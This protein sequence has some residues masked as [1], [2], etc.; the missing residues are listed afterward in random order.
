MGEAIRSDWPIYESIMGEFCVQ[1][2]LV[3]VFSRP[4]MLDL[5][6]LM[7]ERLLGIFPLPAPV[8][9][10]DGE[11]RTPE[12][13]VGEG[14]DEEDP[15]LAGPVPAQPARQVGDH[16]CL[17]VVNHRLQGGHFDVPDKSRT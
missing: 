1:Y 11:E 2:K 16:P 10:S 6:H 4:S 8:E 15:H 14:D 12:E 17:A 5:S 3:E 13:D 9:E 7:R